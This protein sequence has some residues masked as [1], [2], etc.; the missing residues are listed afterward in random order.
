MNTLLRRIPVKPLVSRFRCSVSKPLCSVVENAT[1]FRKDEVFPKGENFIVR[2]SP[3]G[4]SFYSVNVESMGDFRAVRI[5]DPLKSELSGT[6][7]VG[8]CNGLVCLWKPATSDD[9]DDIFLWNPTTREITKLPRAYNMPI[10]CILI[11]SS[12]IGFGYDHVND[13]YKV[14][15][16]YDS[17]IYNILVSVYSLKSNS[18]TRA[19]TISNDIRFFGNFGV[20]SNGSLYWLARSGPNIIAFDLAVHEH[21]MLPFPADV[22]MNAEPKIGLFVFNKCLCLVDRY[23]DSL[24]NMWLLTDNGVENSWSKLLSLEQPGTLGSSKFVRPVAFSKTR[25]EILLS[26]DHEKLVWYDC[27]SNEV[28]NVTLHEFPCPFDMLV[29][30]ESLV[31]TYSN[32]RLQ[33]EEEEFQQLEQ[34]LEND[35]RGYFDECGIKYDDSAIERIMNRAKKGEKFSLEIIMNEVKKGEESVG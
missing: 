5:D 13:D 32:S 22:D 6:L 15:R 28:K 33:S 27:E 7:Y 25:N 34:E 20:F 24:T 23:P 17:Q 26:A 8:S 19:E 12:V 11:G 3:K 29:Y 18:W 9:D 21:K 2:N 16:T 1:S 35:L 30:N 14:M 10:P 4:E 31:Q